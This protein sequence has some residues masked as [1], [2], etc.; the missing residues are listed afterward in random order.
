LQDIFDSPCRRRE[1]MV[2]VAVAVFAI[3]FLLLWLALV[4]AQWFA[5]LSGKGNVEVFLPLG[6]NA[7]CLV[8]VLPMLP[9]ILRQRQV[10]LC[11]DDLTSTPGLD[12]RCRYPA[13][14]QR[15]VQGERLGYPVIVL[16]V[17]PERDIT[18]WLW[19]RFADQ[20]NL[21]N[22]NFVRQPGIVVM[23]RARA[24]V[25]AS[26]ELHAAAGLQGINRT[27]VFARP[28]PSSPCKLEAGDPAF[29]QVV[30]VHVAEPDFPT[31]QRIVESPQLRAR[32]AGA[33]AD[34]PLL[35]AR[36]AEGSGT[37]SLLGGSALD[38]PFDHAGFLAIE[39]IPTPRHV[40]PLVEALDGVVRVAQSIDALFASGSS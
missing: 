13:R 30:Q 19:R 25:P 4:P 33:F 21:F 7:F 36:R 28:M 6:L 16:P 8:L 29:D 2:A 1:R 27:R 5:F 9:R 31:V 23:A 35:Y 38:A 12:K 3:P 37:A 18:G 20:T 15:W 11:F 26:L 17:D 34:H 10:R 14:V 32:L 22:F 40:A 24:D 39:W